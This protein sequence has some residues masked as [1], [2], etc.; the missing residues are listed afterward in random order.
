MSQI[1]TLKVVPGVGESQS[2]GISSGVPKPGSFRGGHRIG[3]MREVSGGYRGLR[4]SMNTAVIRIS[5]MSS[6]YISQ[7]AADTLESTRQASLTWGCGSH[8]AIRSDP[9]VSHFLIG[10]IR[11]VISHAV[12]ANYGHVAVVLVEVEVRISHGRGMLEEGRAQMGSSEGVRP[13][14]DV[15]S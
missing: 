15:A 8:M 11:Q 5:F 4:L 3:S 12:P 9:V 13:G 7:A 6:K 10:M 14:A 1:N 2:N